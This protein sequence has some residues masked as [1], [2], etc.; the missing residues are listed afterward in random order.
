[1]FN[2]FGKIDISGRYNSAD[3]EQIWQSWA[4]ERAYR[5]GLVLS[6]SALVLSLL[7]VAIN[8]IYLGLFEALADCVLVVGCLASVLMTRKKVAERYFVWWPMLLGYWISIGPNTWSTGGITSPFFSSF[9]LLL[10]VGAVVIQTEFKLRVVVAAVL[11][12]IAAWGLFEFFR[13]LTN[14]SD[15]PLIYNMILNVDCLIA[16]AVCIYGFLKTEKDLAREFEMRYLELSQ[17]QVSLSKEESANASKSAFLANISHELRTPLGAILGYIDLLLTEKTSETDMVEQLSI[18]KRNGHQ[19]SSLVDDLLDL[20]K[21]EA[22]RLEIERFEVSLQS[23]LREIYELFSLS[24][25]KKG[26]AFHIK[27]LNPVPK[28]MNLD[29]VRLRQILINLVGNAIKFTDEGKIEIHV[30]YFDSIQQLKFS[31]RDSGRGLTREEQEKLFQPFS[32][33]DASTARKYGGTGLGLNLS[34]KLAKLLNGDLKLAFSRPGEGSIFT[35]WIDAAAVTDKLDSEFT[36]AHAQLVPQ[37]LP[38]PPQGTGVLSGLNVLIVDDTADNRSLIRKFLELAGAQ[39][40]TAEDGASGMQKA[41]SEQIDIVLMD[42]QMPGIDGLQATSLLRQKNFKK[43]IIALT[44]HAMNK[45]RERCLDS[46][47]SEYLA[48]PVN[49]RELISTIHRLVS[50]EN[51]STSGSTRTQ[52][53]SSFQS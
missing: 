36:V 6:S 43:P 28:S 12:N 23:L 52:K 51:R 3:R 11:A 47:C 49:R 37:I 21:I 45:D 42:I 46:G 53:L 50:S 4:Q 29:P 39:V 7:A 34:K 35:L 41:L 27:Y 1:M 40:Q 8:Y 13:P 15:I 17:A 25:S 2:L 32:Q 22:G 20:S 26:L 33:A 48:K 18:V 44:A 14:R 38:Q 16:V 31:V 9:M 19:L 5:V 24:A 10:L 30:E